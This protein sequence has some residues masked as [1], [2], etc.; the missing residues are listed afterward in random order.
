MNADVSQLMGRT[1]VVV[2]HPDDEA[3]GCGALLQRMR[4]PAVLFCTDGAPRDEYFWK[5]HGSREAYADL[6]R[7]EARAALGRVGVQRAEFLAVTDQEL[8][9]CLAAAAAQIDE[10]LTRIQPDAILTLAYEGGHPD[11]D[12][13]ALLAGTLGRARGIPVWE[14]PL[15]HRDRDAQPVV[16]CFVNPAAS[17]I[18][19]S[20]S[21]AELQRKGRM[22]AEYRSQGD[23]LASFDVAKERFRPM[24]AYDFT[25]PPHEGPTNYECWKWRMSCTE[26][27][28]AFREWLASKQ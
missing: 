27:T 8:Y 12:S 14:F 26:V 6:R 22:V 9:R 2:A 5:R 4:E 21:P 1:L 20:P 10:A 28:A 17:E 11:H 23:V 18:A 19:I 16:Q 7:S 25:R 3:A 13:C 15:Y 24:A